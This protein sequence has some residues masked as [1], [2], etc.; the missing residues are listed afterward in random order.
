MCTLG[1]GGRPLDVA[2]GGEVARFC[3]DVLSRLLGGA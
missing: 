3:E 1:V 2:L